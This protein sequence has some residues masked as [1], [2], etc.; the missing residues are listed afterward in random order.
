[1]WEAAGPWDGQD[2]SL[3]AH[4]WEGNPGLPGLLDWGGRERGAGAGY[5]TYCLPVAV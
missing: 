3:R 2:C 5:P 1:M 4:Q